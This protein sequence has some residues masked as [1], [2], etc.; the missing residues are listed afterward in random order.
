MSTE[1]IRSP[2]PLTAVVV[3]L[4]VESTILVESFPSRIFRALFSQGIHQIQIAEEEK[5]SKEGCQAQSGRQE[6]RGRLRIGQKNVGSYSVP[7]SSRSAPR[8]MDSHWTLARQIN[9]CRRTVDETDDAKVIKDSKRDPFKHRKS[10]H[11][12]KYQLH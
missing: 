10:L 12:P 6:S 4:S 11:F 2:T 7:S 3:L 8:S 1:A 5:W 9:V